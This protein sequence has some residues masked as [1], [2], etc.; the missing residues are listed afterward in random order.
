M[1]SLFIIAHC[2][3]LV[4]L[5]LLLLLLL[6]YAT[7]I[8]LCIHKLDLIYFLRCFCSF[9]VQMN[10]VIPSRLF[11]VSSSLYTSIKK[12]RRRRRRRR[13]KK[14]TLNEIYSLFMK[15]FKYESSRIESMLDIHIHS[16]IL[17]QIYAHNHTCAPRDKLTK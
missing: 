6:F 11:R 5:L 9:F 15:D 2:F 12:T 13:T 16:P 1:C 4:F 17:T 3:F 8:S 14:T 10:I 7:N